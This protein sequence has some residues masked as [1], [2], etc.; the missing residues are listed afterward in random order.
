MASKRWTFESAAN[1]PMDGLPELYMLGYDDLH[2]AVPLGEH[3]HQDAFEFVFIEK[4]QAKWEIHGESFET[5][6]GDVFHSQ[7]GEPHR[8]SY[9]VIE[10]CRFWW[11][12]LRTPNYVSGSHSNGVRDH[13]FQQGWLRLDETE[14]E[15]L[16]TS[17]WRLPR[18]IQAGI[19]AVEPLRKLK[20]ALHRQDFLDGV[21][22]RLAVVEFLLLLVR[23]SGNPRRP[24]DA[25]TKVK[26]ITTEMASNPDLRP[27]VAELARVAG[28]SPSHFYRIFQE[29]TGLTP[30]SYMERIRI[31]EACRRLRETSHS[32]TAIAHDLGYMSS[33]HFSTVFRRFTGATPTK[34]RAG[35]TERVK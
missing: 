27:S 23:P 5:R 30:M 24:D 13:V 35:E 25:L 16:L 1:G 26:N 31:D 14:T 9:N 11:M 33:Q 17:L 12:I 32:I 22:G 6:T 28:V 10:P 7:P 19:L 20:K 2:K 29:Y 3:R 8:G 21:E 4:G 15:S 34:W 18:V